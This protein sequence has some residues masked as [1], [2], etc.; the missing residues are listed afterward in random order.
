M[1]WIN[2]QMSENTH[3][4]E[5]VEKGK[6]KERGGLCVKKMQKQGFLRGRAKARGMGDRPG[7]N[8]QHHDLQT[9]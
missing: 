8:R 7:L 5:V 4:K 6:G 2:H 1:E 3:R 9:G